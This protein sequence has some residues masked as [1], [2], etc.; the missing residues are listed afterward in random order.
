MDIL[1]A[2]DK[3]I[4]VFLDDYITRIGYQSTYSLKRVY[5]R[6]PMVNQNTQTLFYYASSG[7]GVVYQVQIN[8]PGTLTGIPVTVTLDGFTTTKT[9]VIGTNNATFAEGVTYRALDANTLVLYSLKPITYIF[10]NLAYTNFTATINFPLGYGYDIDAVNRIEPIS[11][12]KFGLIGADQQYTGSSET[13]YRTVLIN[14]NGQ[15][16]NVAKNSKF[17]LFN[18]IEK[19]FT[20]ANED[21]SLRPHYDFIGFE[22][23][24]LKMNPNLTY[25]EPTIVGGV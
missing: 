2:S 21:V 5:K 10:F 11:T 14:G 20:S 1:Q 16:L 23:L 6:I 24:G 12:M 7:Q 22:L 4:R 8:F 3:Q 19:S 18:Y 9:I 17:A 13:F 25:P 15:Y